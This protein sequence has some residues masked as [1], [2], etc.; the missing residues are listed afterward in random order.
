MEAA[1]LCVTAFGRHHSTDIR[2]PI[3][4]LVTNNYKRISLILPLY[5]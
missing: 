2:F 1:R 3:T 4:G 5:S